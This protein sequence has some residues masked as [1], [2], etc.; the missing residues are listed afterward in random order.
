MSRMHNAKM[1]RDILSAMKAGEELSVGKVA[2]QIGMH[3]NLTY[4][5]K[6]ADALPLGEPVEIKDNSGT[7][8]GVLI[9]RSNPSRANDSFGMVVRWT[10]FVGQNSG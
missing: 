7:V 6:V 1:H 10:P 4:K 9:R 3:D 5:R 2:V 8:L